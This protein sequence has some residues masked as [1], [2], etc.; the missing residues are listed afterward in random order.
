MAGGLASGSLITWISLGTQLQMAKGNIR[1][2]QKSI[3]VDGCNANWILEYLSLSLHLDTTAKPTESPFLF[4][5]L[6]Y[7][8]YTALGCV[9][10]IVIGSIVSY[11][12]GCNKKSPVHRDLL[13]PVIH[14]FLNEDILDKDK[15]VQKSD[16]INLNGL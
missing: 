3:S 5:R 1:F 7:M 10:T 9:T 15:D 14:R 6:S 16:T 2:P 13:S 12:T 4:Y 8:Y 11:L